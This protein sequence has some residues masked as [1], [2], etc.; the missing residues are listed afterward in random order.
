MDMKKLCDKLIEDESLKDIPLTY[1]FRVALS[2]FE[3]IN[4]GDF[5]YEN[6]EQGG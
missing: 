2:L 3:L 5:F 6:Y 1:V 4:S